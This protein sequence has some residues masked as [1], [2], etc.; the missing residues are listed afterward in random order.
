MHLNVKNYEELYKPTLGICT[1]HF[2]ILFYNYVYCT[3]WLL[4]YAII[5]HINILKIIAAFNFSVTKL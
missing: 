4:S 5:I 2:N 3:A 1:N